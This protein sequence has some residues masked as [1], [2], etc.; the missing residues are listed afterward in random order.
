MGG[1]V[2]TLFGGSKSK[3]QST[4]GNNAFNFLMNA[5]G[6]NVSTG[7]SAIETIGNL[8]GIGSG[9]NSGASDAA[10]NSYKNST[11]FENR[12]KTGS[13]AIT[14]SAAAKGLLNSGSTLKGLETFGQNL[15]SEEFNN[16]LKQVSG[17]A[18]AGLNA[19]QILSGAGQTGQST[20]SGSQNNGIFK[21]IKLFG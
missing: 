18:E 1:I 12:L 11:G 21:S 9:A 16:Y 13:D 17:V 19:G 5:L 14:G 8:L 15:G 4:Q 7:S 10:F 2:K 3:N 20:G 6:G